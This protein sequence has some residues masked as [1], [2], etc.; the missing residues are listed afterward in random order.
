M[1]KNCTTKE[2]ENVDNVNSVCIVN[3]LNFYYMITWIQIVLQKHHKVVFSILLVAITIAFVFTIGSIPFFGDRNRYEATKQDFYGFDLSNS[4][5][6]SYLNTYAAFDAM[7]EGQR[8]SDAY[9]YKQAYLRYMAKSLGI[10]Q[11]DQKV[12]DSYIKSSPIFM[13]KDGKFDDNL[14]KSFIARYVASGNITEEALTQ[15]FA[16]NAMLNSVEELLGG[17]GYVLKSDVETRYNMLHG[18]WD[19][20]LAVIPF[21]SFK[22]EIKI[23]ASKLDSFYKQNAAQF[24]IG[25]GVVLETV[26][27]PLKD[28]AAQV[29]VPSDADLNAHYNANITKYSETK[30][31]IPQTKPF[32]SVKA[33]VKADFLKE[34]AAHK[35]VSFAET[36]ALKIYDSKAKMASPELKKIL[37]DAKVVVKKSN[38]MRSTDKEMDKTLPSSVVS[39]GFK[40]DEQAFYADPIVTDD[41]VWLVFLAE[42]LAAYQPKLDA[43]KAEVEKAYLESEK[44]RLFVEYGNKL[45]ASF[46]KGLKEGKSFSAIAK[47]N[48]VDVEDVKN[49]SLMNPMSATGKVRAAFQVLNAELPKLK[50]GGISKMQVSG[51][52]GFIVNLTNFKKPVADAKRIS[53]IEKNYAQ[54]MKSVAEQSILSQ[55]ISQGE[56]QNK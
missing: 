51:V 6:A 8:P 12:L 52:N 47:A 14:F 7:L 50:V 33:K 49:F 11:V 46:E 44:Q 22:P 15:I 32:N 37:N 3:G 2:N 41:G 34:A 42:K 43:V 27:L 24:R 26:F 54:A 23:D 55:A 35:A 17:P 10:K 38:A 29:P 36:I 31:G 28:F 5:V 25:D 39:A 20:N 40:L 45:Y 56:K 13:D 16:E 19:F 9:I 4:G 30:D 21:D 1:L 48:N 18:T 53:E